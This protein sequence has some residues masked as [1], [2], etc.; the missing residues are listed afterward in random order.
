MIINKIF[1]KYCIDDVNWG[2]PKQMNIIKKWNLNS[3]PKINKIG[4]VEADKTKIIC[5][6]NKFKVK[7][8]KINLLYN[9]WYSVH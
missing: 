3:T 2:N 8:I 1:I 5:W 4:I 7:I 9:D 6:K